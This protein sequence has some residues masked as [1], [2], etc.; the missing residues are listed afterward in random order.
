M[1]Y[2]AGRQEVPSRRVV[3][4]SMAHHEEAH[5]KT[6]QFIET[7]VMQFKFYIV[8][9]VLLMLII[10]MVVGSIELGL[11][12][13]RHFLEPPRFLFDAAELLE[14]FSFALLLLIGLELIESV[15]LYLFH[16]EVS[17][18]VK[19]VVSIGI[20]AIA[21]K[22]IVLDTKKTEPLIV[23]GIAAIFL[24]LSIGF[25]LTTARDPNHL[26]EDE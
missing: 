19:P 10:I 5:P 24:S 9:F 4:Q 17:V 16:S 7:V 8:S 18:L 2:C 3:F 15:E 11:T 23:I 6:R 12:A 13:I 14:V 26:S 25:Y 22:I 20:I 21:R 1:G